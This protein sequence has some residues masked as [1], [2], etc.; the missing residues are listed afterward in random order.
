LAIVDLE[1]DDLRDIDRS[2]RPNPLPNLDKAFGS[3]IL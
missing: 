1:S 3:V 2:L